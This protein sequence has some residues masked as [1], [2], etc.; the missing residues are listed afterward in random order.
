MGLLGRLLQEQAGLE[1]FLTI[2]HPAP[3]PVILNVL[4]HGSPHSVISAMSVLRLLAEKQET[5]RILVR[6]M[7]NWGDLVRILNR[8]HGLQAQAQAARCI[9]LCAEF[10]AGDQGSAAFVRDTI[11]DLGALELLVDLCLLASY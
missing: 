9:G 10:G 1:A 7:K 5:R 4:A 3:I 11:G 8:D 6:N 2:R